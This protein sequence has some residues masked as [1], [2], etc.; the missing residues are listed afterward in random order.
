MS[1]GAVAMNLGH[2][3]TVDNDAVRVGKDGKVSRCLFRYGEY[4]QYDVLDKMNMNITA[5]IL[6]AILVTFLLI[7]NTFT[8]NYDDA[9]CDG[10]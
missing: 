7:V 6:H 4:C 5:W 8:D 3:R 10:Y 1:H 9:Y 2:P